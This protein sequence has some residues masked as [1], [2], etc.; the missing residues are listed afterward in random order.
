MLHIIGRT[1]VGFGQGLML[2][3]GPVYLGEIA[4]TEI[5]GA[6]LTI[7][8]V[9]YTLGTV[10]SYASTLYTTTASN[11]LGNWQWRYVLLGQAVTPLLF[12]L[13]I[14]HC[15]ES[16]RWLVLKGR[17][18]D[19]RGVLMMLRD[20]EDVEAELAD[21]AVVIERDQSENP[22]VFGA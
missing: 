18:D 21:M 11:V 2:S 20:E 7:W 3:T 13:C 8:K 17:H 16:P 15:P 9:F 4:P 1:C 22:G 12:L 19:A 14:P 6:I 10:F 5:R